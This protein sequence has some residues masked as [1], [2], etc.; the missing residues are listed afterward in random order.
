MDDLSRIRTFIK[1]VDAGS[2]SAAARHEFSVSSVARQVKSL[3]DE[4]GI[5]LL[6]RSTRHLS[7]TEP[8]RLF[9]E[10]AVAISNDLNTAKREAASFQGN[11]K[12]L[13]RVSLR[14]SAGACAIVPALPKFLEQYPELTVD[15]SL[16]DERVDLIANNIDVAVWSGDLPNADIVGRQLSPSRRIVCASPAYFARAGTPAV[17]E[18]LKR[19]NCLL[20]KA[21]THADIWLFERDG[22]SQE[23]KIDGNMQSSNGIALLSG[24]L[25]GL[26]IIVV[27]E[28][29]VRSDLE[30]GRLA[31]VLNDY[32][33]RP[34]TVEAPVHVVFPSSQGMSLKVRAFVD[35]LVQLFRE[36]GLGPAVQ[37]STKA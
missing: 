24:A 32:V 17:P 13:L 19:H 35:F 4:L 3:E 23:V 12:G 14:I 34:T 16:T 8:G 27:H 33:V 25:A 21:P 29:M 2:F 11:V 20:F 9:Y 30:Q 5:R 22:V 26:G 6:N 18:D 7:L 1:V 37:R 36:P 28:W 15:V 31:R 10:R